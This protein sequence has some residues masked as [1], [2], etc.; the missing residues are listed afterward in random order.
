MGPKPQLPMEIVD[1]KLDALQTE[2]TRNLTEVRS[3]VLQLPL[4]IDFLKSEVQRLP[5][6]EKKMDF[7][8][9]HLAQLLQSSGRATMDGVATSADRNRPPPEGTNSPVPPGFSAASP[10]PPPPPNLT[11]PSVAPFDPDC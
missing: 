2:F 4:Q 1:E 3:E 11:T 7:L 9:T 5:E 10:V 8:V 6:I